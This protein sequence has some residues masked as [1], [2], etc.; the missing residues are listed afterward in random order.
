MAGEAVRDV[1]N[2]V[3][4]ALSTLPSPFALAGGLALAVWGYPRATRDVDLLIGVESSEF[5]TL[6]TTLTSHGCRPKHTPP[7]IPVG[8]Y[9]IAQFLF[10][11]PNEFYDVQFDLLLAENDLL[12]SALQRAQKQEVPG[13]DRPIRVLSC[14]DLMLLKLLAGR[15]LDLSD[16]AMLLRENHASLDHAYMAVW[17]GKLNLEAAYEEARQSAFPEE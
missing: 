14:E 8:P 11:P 5:D 17:L 3:A 6:L 4:N 16:V 10:T 13:L 1:L 7:L 2:H 9:H 15:V 12:K